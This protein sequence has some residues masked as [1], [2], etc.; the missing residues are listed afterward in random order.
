MAACTALAITARIVRPAE[1]AAPASD[2][3][4]WQGQL[5][6]GLSRLHKCATAAAEAGDAALLCRALCAARAC[7]QLAAACGASLS[8][9]VRFCSCQLQFTHKN[10][11]L[12]AL[13]VLMQ[14]CHS[15]LLAQHRS[16]GGW[17]AWLPACLGR[18]RV[19]SSWRRRPCW[20]C[21]WPTTY[22][23]SAPLAAKQTLRPISAGSAPIVT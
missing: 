2:V 23:G 13:R 20:R 14:Y 19:R 22:A 1:H 4:W 8:A 3:A 10:V 11:S 5:E 18:R 15:D 17:T 16:Q 7:L 9:H 21:S 12:H 6:S